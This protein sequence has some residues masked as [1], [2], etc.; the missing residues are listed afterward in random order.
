[1]KFRIFFTTL[2]LLQ[3]S[4]A[5]AITGNYSAGQEK[6][7]SCIPCHGPTGNSV[8]PEWPKIAGQHQ[9]YLVKQIKEIK[10]GE[11]GPRSIPVMLGTVVELSDQDIADIATFY[12]SEKQ[13]GGQVQS[14]YLAL[15]RKIYLGGNIETGVPACLACHG[16][17]GMGNSAANYP[18]VAGQ[19]AA[20][21]ELQLDH[22]RQG[23]RK[24]DPSGMMQYIAKK[25]S[26]EEIKAVSSY[27]EGLHQ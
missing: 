18:R 11:E 1:M 3:I 17:Q 8:N 10:M 25:M 6:S 19:H 13:T 27:I 16:P 22:F 5:W 23:N 21:T 20:Y 4:N 15:G 2:L 14:Q 24:N 9:N 26:D 7:N 12:A